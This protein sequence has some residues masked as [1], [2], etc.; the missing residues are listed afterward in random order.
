[1]L[2]YAN[3][4]VRLSVLTPSTRFTVQGIII[5]LFFRCM[6]TLLNP[7]HHRG[8]GIKWVLM[9]H[10]VAMFSLATGYTA[11]PSDLQFISYIDSRKFPG[12]PFPDSPLG[13]SSTFLTRGSSLLPRCL[14]LATP[15]APSLLCSLCH[16]LPG[17]CTPMPGVPCFLG[18]R[19]SLP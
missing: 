10:T 13:T 6:S 18:T 16:E 19:S 4:C 1:M 11:V 2:R 12:F 5:V 9:G 3:R 15:L 7:V 14:T 17:H 8:R